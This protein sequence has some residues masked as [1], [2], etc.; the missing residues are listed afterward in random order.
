M[1]TPVRSRRLLPLAAL[2]CLLTASACAAA[3]DDPASGPS[4][5]STTEPAL[6]D[7]ERLDLLWADVAAAQAELRLH[8]AG[9]ILDCLETEGFTV[10]NAEAMTGQW[11]HTG[12]APSRV[13]ANLDD[14]VGLP[15]A[16]EAESRALGHWLD[17]ADAYGDQE[18]I[19]LR[20]AELTA[21]AETDE[22][23]GVEVDLSSIESA[24]EG[25]D[26]L[27]VAD[28][29][30]WE[31]AYRGLDWAVTSKTASV[32]G[33]D[34]WAALDL[35][36]EQWAPADTV[37]TSPQ[38]CQGEALT[39]LHGEPRRVDRGFGGSQWVWGPTVD[40]SADMLGSVDFG[41]L[42]E[43]DAFLACLADAGHPDWTLTD[44][45]T[46][47]VHDHWRDQYLPEAA[48]RHEDGTVEYRHSDITDADRERYEAVKSDEFAAAAVIVSCDEASGYTETAT[49]GSERR[50]TE[51]FLDIEPAQRDY[52]AELQAVLDGVEP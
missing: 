5:S 21:D 34:D 2:A 12:P 50:F 43:A 37:S 8:E 7:L 16:A 24:G 38:G 32:L 36:G 49:A 51:S 9:L 3:D 4:D 6:G 13:I 14:P 45:G 33:A 17:F 39:A 22:P 46:L 48:Q 28:Q 30:A 27:A 15:D 1:E 31:I 42:P 29:M 10:H 11:H 18:G 35:P 47:D 44:T 19:D 41:S 23:E 40:V 26:A 20:E 52:L 25:W